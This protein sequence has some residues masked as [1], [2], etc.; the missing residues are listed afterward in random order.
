MNLIQTIEDYHKLYK[1]ST[2]RP[3]K[4]WESIANDFTW[5]K[6]WDK[7]LE[8]DFN[9]PEVKWFIGGKLNITENCLD[10]HLP[11]RANQTAMIWEPNDPSQD[12][13][14]ITYQQLHDEVCRT[15]NMLK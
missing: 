5:R 15:A 6:K 7:V 4:F 2:D 13:K 14:H 11:S 3:E 9:K 8:W 12:A 1:E 10:R